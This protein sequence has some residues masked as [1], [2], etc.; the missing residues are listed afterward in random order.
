MENVL[1]YAT[2]LMGMIVTI[3]ATVSQLINA[4]GLF[5]PQ[6]KNVWM[7]NVR[8]YVIANMATNAILIISVFPLTSVLI[9]CAHM[10]INVIKDIVFKSMDTGMIIQLILNLNLFILSLILIILNLDIPVM[11]DMEITVLPTQI[12][13]NNAFVLVTFVKLWNA[14]MIG[15]AMVHHANMEN[16]LTKRNTIE[17]LLISH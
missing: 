14:N 13:R 16:A 15:N 1:K 3:G 17:G 12:A 11:E 8:K 9:S 10:G 2:A 4:H 6:V 5:V 7:V